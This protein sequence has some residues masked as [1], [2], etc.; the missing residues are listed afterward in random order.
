M[1]MGLGR[2]HNSTNFFLVDQL[3]FAPAF[4]G[5]LIG[6]IGLLQGNKPTDVKKKLEREFPDIL[7][8]NYKLW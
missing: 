1:L 4:I 6:S 2:R 7:K 8:A 5:V 3:V